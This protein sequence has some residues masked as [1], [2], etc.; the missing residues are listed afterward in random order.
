MNNDYIYTKTVI[1]GAGVSG[2]STATNLLKNG[3]NEFLIYEALDRFG[4][5]CHSVNYENSFIEYGAQVELNTILDNI[6]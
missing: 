6:A 3:Y 5:R 2:I 1:I 4:G